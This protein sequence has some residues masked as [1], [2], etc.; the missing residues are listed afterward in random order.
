MRTPKGGW[1]YMT[2]YDFFTVVFLMTVCIAALL[3]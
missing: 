3:K 1:T 2:K